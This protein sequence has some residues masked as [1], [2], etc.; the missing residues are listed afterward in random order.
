MGDDPVDDSAL[1]AEMVVDWI[2]VYQTPEQ[3]GAGPTSPYIQGATGGGSRQGV[4]VW[5]DD[6]SNGTAVC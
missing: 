4:M 3:Y 2:R 1:P 5:G 6:F